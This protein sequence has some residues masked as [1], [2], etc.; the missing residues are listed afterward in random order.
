MTAP[1]DRVAVAV[2]GGADS[3]ALLLA[4]V[5]LAPELGL[6]L[7]VAHLDHGLRPD[8]A[9]D[10]D[11]VRDRAAALGLSFQARRADLGAACGNLEQR[12]RRARLEFFQSLRRS[13]AAGVIATAHTLD[14]QAET[15]LMRILRGA[16]GRGLAGIW[17][18]IRTAAPPPNRPAVPSAV[19]PARP[20]LGRADPVRELFPAPRGGRPWLIRPALGCRRAELRAWLRA[21]GETWREDAT[22][23]D[24]GRLRNRI[25]LRLLPALERE[26]NPELSSRLADLAE[27]ARADEEFWAAQTARAARRIW[28]VQAGGGDPA[29]RD[30]NPADAATVQAGARGAVDLCAETAALAGLGPALGRRVLR[31]AVF[32]VR[33]PKD[34]EGEGT[35]PA[36]RMVK[37]LDFRSLDAAWRRVLAAAGRGSKV[38]FRP[39]RLILAGVECL[40]GGRFVRLRPWERGVAGDALSERPAA[41]GYNQD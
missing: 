6:Q 27:M 10:A 22:N 20:P 30:R 2:S 24:L 4:L 21:R 12:A 1:G 3:M 17:P 8:S 14:D 39:G 31:A 38:D 5:E 41:I 33:F 9:A 28:R 26:Y 11:F 15:V 29:S 40:V 25:R 7:A 35:G 34:V 32:A 16:G 18:V 13:G 36:R 23:Q 37:E 19:H